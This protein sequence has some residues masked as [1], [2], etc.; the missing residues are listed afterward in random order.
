MDEVEQP[1]DD[2]CSSAYYDDWFSPWRQGQNDLEQ[3]N[4]DDADTATSELSD[5]LPGNW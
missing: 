3:V 2:V 5:H 1:E 4:D